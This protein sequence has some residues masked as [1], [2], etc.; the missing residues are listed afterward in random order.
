MIDDDLSG[1]HP[2]DPGIRRTIEEISRRTSEE[3]ARSVG[4]GEDIDRTD[5]SNVRLVRG[6][7]WETYISCWGYAFDFLNDALF[8]GLLPACLLTLQKHRNCYGYFAGDRY[9]A[10]DGS[11]RTDEIA[12]NPTHLRSLTVRDA[13]STLGH[14]MA[15]LKRYRFVSPKPTGGYHDKQWARIMIEI[16]LIPSTTGAE[17][18]AQTGYRVS[19]YIAPGGRFDLAC[20]EL[21]RRGFGIR[22]VE[23]GGLAALD[24]G[25]AEKQRKK[26]NESKTKFFCPA[27]QEQNAWAKLSSRFLCGFCMVAMEVADD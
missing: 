4:H 8:E 24:D 27:C 25:E 20:A 22:Y 3:V 1:D 12:I 13:L 23:M 7:T 21:L 6:P 17:G 14:E 18:G 11:G 10:P 26:K 16:G 19:H 9:G 2:E 15:H 5:D